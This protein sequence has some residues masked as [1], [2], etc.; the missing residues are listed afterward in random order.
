M[1]SG[2]PDDDM[3][4]YVLKH[5]RGLR[6]RDIAAAE[7][8]GDPSV[9]VEDGASAEPATDSDEGAD[10]TDAD[11]QV[12]TITRSIKRAEEHLGVP[13]RKDKPGRRP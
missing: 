8:R 7:R 1:P 10:G 6:V 9:T 4:R 2:T 13:A 5:F 12:R 3:R 11:A